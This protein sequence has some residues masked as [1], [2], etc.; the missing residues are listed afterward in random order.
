MHALT[1]AWPLQAMEDVVVRRAV[2][3]AAFVAGL[4]PLHAEAVQVVHS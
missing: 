4:T 1:A 3:R 2:Q